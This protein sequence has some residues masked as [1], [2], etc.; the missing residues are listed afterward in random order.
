MCG[1]FAPKAIP[2][3]LA[4]A[5]GLTAPASANALMLPIHDRMPGI[6]PPDAWEMWLDIRLQKRDE[7]EE[8]LRPIAKTYLRCGKTEAHELRQAIR[9]D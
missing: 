1:C 5:F 6:L 8:L 3:P 2:K 4:E 7:L 9:R